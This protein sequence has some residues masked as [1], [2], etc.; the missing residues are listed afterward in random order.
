MRAED[1]RALERRRWDLVDAEKLRARAERY[2]REGAEGCVR[3]A[4]ALRDQARALGLAGDRAEDL[5]AHVAWRILLD[6]A[7]RNRIARPR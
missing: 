4:E 1:E 3:A 2:W 7:E 6:R 5:R